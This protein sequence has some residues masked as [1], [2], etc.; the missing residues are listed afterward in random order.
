MENPELYNADSRHRYAPFVTNRLE[1]C[2]F[3][4]TDKSFQMVSY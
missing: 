3:F 2:S 1:Y 4:V